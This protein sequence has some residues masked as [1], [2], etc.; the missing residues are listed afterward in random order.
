M[1]LGVTEETGR[2]AWRMHTTIGGDSDG[3]WEK[4]WDPDA[5]PESEE[6]ANDRYQRLLRILFRPR[7]DET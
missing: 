6:E 2:G 5:T 7:S 4:Y 1:L 3:K